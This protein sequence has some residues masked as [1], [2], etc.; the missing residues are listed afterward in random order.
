[1]NSHKVN[2]ASRAAVLEVVHGETAA[3]YQG[4]NTPSVYGPES[5]RAIDAAISSALHSTLSHLEKAN[6]R[7]H[8]RTSSTITSVLVFLK[9]VS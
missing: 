6:T 7:G 9:A 2:K 5:N 3:P 8:T 4:P 1:M